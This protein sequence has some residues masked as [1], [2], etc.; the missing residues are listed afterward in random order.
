[1]KE[2]QITEII[3]DFL[4]EHVYVIPP[5]IYLLQPTIPMTTISSRRLQLPNTYPE[6]ISFCQL[7][8]GVQPHVSIVTSLAPYKI[9]CNGVNT[10]LIEIQCF[11]GRSVHVIP[12]IKATTFFRKEMIFLKISF[13]SKIIEEELY[14][15]RPLV[16][17]FK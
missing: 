1:M 2:K 3:L 5:R 17:M 6:F 8:L 9:R 15:I 14:A 10:L 13:S 4:T 11:H 12:K 7:Y 16:E